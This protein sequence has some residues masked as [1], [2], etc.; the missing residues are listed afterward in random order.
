MKTKHYILLFLLATM[1]SEIKLTAAATMPLCTALF[2]MIIVRS[3]S[4]HYITDL[5]RYL[6]SSAEYQTNAKVSRA[7]NH[8]LIGDKNFKE[9]QTSIERLLVEHKLNKTD[10]NVTHAADQMG[11]NRTTLHTWLKKYDSHKIDPE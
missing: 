1:G 10:Y 2:I 9:T 8:Y 7:V 6:P 4:S 5:R 11:I 3:E